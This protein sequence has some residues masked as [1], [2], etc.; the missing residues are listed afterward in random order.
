[1]N[2]DYAEPR[3]WDMHRFD[4]LTYL[5]FHYVRHLVPF[6]LNRAAA[7][8]LLYP[9]QV[10]LFT[11]ITDR[12]HYRCFHDLVPISLYQPGTVHT[13]YILFIGH[14]WYR[15]GVD[16]LIRAFNEVANDYPDWSLKVVGY[17][18]EKEHFTSLYAH[19]P[20]IEFPGPVMPEK[21]PQLMSKCSLFVL[22]SRSEGMPRVLIEAMASR[23][24]VIASRIN[25]IPYYLRHEQTALLFDSE[26]VRGLV[27]HMRK[28]MSDESFTDKLSESAYKY[29]WTYLSEDQHVIQFMRMVDEITA[30]ES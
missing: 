29:A 2:G 27:A 19:N 8:K 23:K 30:P 12:R 25:G 16:V 22:A 5:K 10:D 21:V 14:P 15:K 24:P 13:K 9:T 26:D 1:V 11:G 7:V 20:Q 17:L 28:V 6:I 4:V 18:P 3:N